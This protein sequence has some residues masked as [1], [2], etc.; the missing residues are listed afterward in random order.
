[1]QIVVGLE[2]GGQQEVGAE[3]FDREIEVAGDALER[4]GDAG[5]GGDFSAGGADFFGLCFED[6]V[7]LRGIP[8]VAVLHAGEEFAGE[9]EAGFGPR[10][11]VGEQGVAGE[12]RDAIEEG[13]GGC[14]GA[15]R[16]LV[17]S[18]VGGGACGGVAGVEAA[19]VGEGE[20]AVAEFLRSS[21]VGGEA[22]FVLIGV[23]GGAE[24]EDVADYPGVAEEFPGELIDGLVEGVA[25]A[26]VGEDGEVGNSVG[27]G[28]LRACFVGVE[29]VGEEGALRFVGTGDGNAGVEAGAG[30]ADFLVISAG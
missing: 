13:F 22:D 11:V 18:L 26:V 20:A 8:V 23:A 3:G 27:V 29:G 21:S 2:I 1:M 15:A 7:A 10:R 16:G 6:A 5:V 4:G 17:G 14:E 19:V 25:V 24:V 12:K 28:E 30:L 9:G